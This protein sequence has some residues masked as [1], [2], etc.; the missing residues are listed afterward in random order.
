MPHCNRIDRFHH[1]RSPQVIGQN[2]GELAIRSFFV[3]HHMSD[4]TVGIKRRTR[5]IGKPGRQP[6]AREMPAQPV[7]VRRRAAEHVV[8]QI[9]REAHTNRDCLPVQQAI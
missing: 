2:E 6:D 5:H 9:K 3:V 4:Q 1:P 7:R 8:R